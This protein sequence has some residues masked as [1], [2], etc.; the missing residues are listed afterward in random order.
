MVKY[1][2]VCASTK[3]PFLEE[4]IPAGVTSHPSFVRCQSCAS[5]PQFSSSSGVTVENKA[6]KGNF[7]YYFLE[8]NKCK[9]LFYSIVEGVP[10]AQS[11]FGVDNCPQCGNPFPL[12]DEVCIDKDGDRE[13]TVLSFPF[14][15]D[16]QL[17]DIK[18]LYDKVV[19]TVTQHPNLAAV[20]RKIM[21]VRK[22]SSYKEI[23]V[24]HIATMRG[25][26]IMTYMLKKAMEE[27]FFSTGS[28]LLKFAMEKKGL[29]V[30]ESIK[31]QAN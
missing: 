30:I 27:E 31:V 11:H 18:A 24:V 23:W 20:I 12:I 1:C 29:E 17:A 26:G 28:Q 15:R 4:S 16:R 25:E 8:C 9:A 14:G 3:G 22:E 6:T 10:C 21:L 7:E 5:T 2:H 13:L 19:C